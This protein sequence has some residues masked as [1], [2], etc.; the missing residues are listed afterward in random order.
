MLEGSYEVLFA[1][2][3]LREKLDVALRLFYH[4]AVG[5]SPL[6]QESD[7]LA[8]QLFRGKTDGESIPDVILA[9]ALALGALSS[10]L[11]TLPVGS[12][13]CCESL[14]KVPDAVRGLIK[15]PN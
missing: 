13:S 7:E 1:C 8:E 14:L 3:L 11:R 9:V 2:R 10:Q 5:L 12:S 6:V 4:N 15:S